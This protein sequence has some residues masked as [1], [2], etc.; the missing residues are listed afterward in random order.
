M[1]GFFDALEKF[2]GKPHK[3]HFVDIDDQHI[4]VT[5]EQK[6]E[7][8]QSGEDSYVC[9]KGPNGMIVCKK[10]V[11]RR[12]QKQKQL[13]KADEGIQLLDKNPFWPTQQGKRGYKWQIK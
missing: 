6:L 5:L 9:Q 7:T 2:K 1:P 10:P 13:T 12:E 8:Q 3:K 11:I 4:E